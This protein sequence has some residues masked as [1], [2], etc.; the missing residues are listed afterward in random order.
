MKCPPNWMQPKRP[1]KRA[2]EQIKY[3]T[4]R[5]GDTLLAIANRTKVPAERLAGS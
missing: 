3:Y 2:P 5:R 4:V 1:E